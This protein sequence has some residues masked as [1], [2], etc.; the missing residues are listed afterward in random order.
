M[1]EKKTRFG[2]GK[3]W[4]RFIKK[5]FSEER[6]T[7]AQKHL[8]DFLEMDHLQGK[9]FLDVGCGSGLHSLSALR[10]G[11]GRIVSFDVDQDSV[12]TTRKLKEFAGNP[13]YWEVREG[14]I[15]DGEFT[16]TVDPADIVYCW[17]VLHHT[18][19][20]WRA[21]ENTVGL[22]KEESLL[23]IALYT[24][25]QYFGLP[26]EFWLDVK[27]RYNRG[28]W[29]MKRKME[30]WYFW[31]FYLH[32]RLSALPDLLK[33]A[34]D[35]KKS[36][37]MAIYTDAVDWLG[38][39]PMEYSTEEEVKRF[40]TEKVGLT[41]INIKTGQANIEY[42][43]G[44]PGQV[45]VTT[46]SFSASNTAS[47][48]KPV[49]LG[50]RN[51]SSD[52]L[53]E[54]MK[55]ALQV[56][57]CYNRWLPESHKN[58][59]DK[60]VLELGPGINFG[61]VLLLACQGAKVMVAD[62]FLAP[63]DGNYHPK[64]YS[65]LRDWIQEKM[66]E[67]DVTSLGKILSTGGYCSESIIC[68]SCAI[69]A[70]SSISD[71]S[72][73][74]VYSN[75]VLEHLY[76]PGAAFRSL[77]RVSKPGALGLHQVDFRY[78]K[79]MDKPLEFLLSNDAEFAKEFE[80]CH[81]ECGNRYRPY[82]YQNLFEAAGFQVLEFKSGLYAETTYLEEFTPRLRAASGSRYQYIDADK[83]REIG[84]FYSLVRKAND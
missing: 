17:G 18:G 46:K 32:K 60:V 31:E 50:G 77:A 43:F 72:V 67:A 47:T 62:R 36:R 1:P 37:G 68:Y 11:A 82:E 54:D 48:Y 3:N 45:S 30:F 13:T 79:M 61:S 14:S 59:R 75:A 2:F 27:Q 73:D 76:D 70:L 40:G 38:G 84:G 42:L 71:S 69:E 34:S 52:V 16:K 5:N 26:K 74:I 66:P 21:F 51:A 15:L 55:Y 23:Y 6:V 53:L 39:W 10:A 35:Y 29:L 80:E 12:N 78:H 28:G 81:G 33:Q 25:T 20:M 41:L 57:Q 58:L 49:N 22:M 19:K 8:L 56:G 4:E 44:R 9:Y 7:I 64:F 83:L 63:W 65:M 24:D